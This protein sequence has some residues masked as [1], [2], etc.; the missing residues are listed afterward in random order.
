MNTII[1][2]TSNRKKKKKRLEK[3]GRTG[4]EVTASLKLRFQISNK[5][6][7]AE[8]DSARSFLANDNTKENLQK[9]AVL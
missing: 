9:L 6:V 1:S 8:R 3:M 2:D 4:T 7:N 5:N